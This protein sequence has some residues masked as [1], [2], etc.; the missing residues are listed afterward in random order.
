MFVDKF[1]DLCEKKGVRLGQAA[2]EMGLS[3]AAV[4]R[5]K[6]YG[7]SPRSESMQRIAD[8]FGVSISSLMEDEK[9]E[10]QALSEKEKRDIAR[11]VDKIMGDL[12]DSGD[13]MF[14]G[15][16]MN[17]EARTAMAAA[18]QTALEVAR[19][20]NKQTYTPKKYRKEEGQ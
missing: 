2:S 18:M 16:P 14:D 7:Y 5:W 9:K 3:G 15:V 4:S 17:D 6:R 12:G 1:A 10:P 20:L 11:E 19:T 13:L 8:Y